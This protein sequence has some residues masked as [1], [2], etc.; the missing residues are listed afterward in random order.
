MLRYGDKGND[1]LNL[2]KILKDLGFFK[3][4]PCGNFRSITRAALRNFQK[5]HRLKVDG[6]Y[7]PECSAKIQQLYE[8]YPKQTNGKPSA[9]ECV[10]FVRRLV[11]VAKYVLGGDGETRNGVVIVDC[12]GLIVKML[13]EK[14]FKSKGFDTTAQGFKGMCKELQAVEN[15]FDLIFNCD[16]KTGRARHVMIYAGDDKNSVIH[17]YNGVECSFMDEIKRRFSKKY[18]IKFG[19]LPFWG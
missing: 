3:V 10:Q 18:D 9:L 16:K 12:S 6:V 15:P 17:A 13:R 4:E 2:Q 1:V 7:G 8:T 11:G 14:G 19:R 5:A